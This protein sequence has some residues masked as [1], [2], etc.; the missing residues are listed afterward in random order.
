MSV[1]LNFTRVFNSRGNAR[2]VMLNQKLLKTAIA[3]ATILGAALLGDFVF[4]YYLFVT[5]QAFTPLNTALIAVL[6]GTPVSYYLISQRLDMQRVKEELC[7]SIAEKD[8]VALELGLRRQ[9]AE[10]AQAG[11][12]LALDQLRESEARYRMLTDRATDIIIRYN[13]Q[14]MIE[15]ASP[16][17]HQIGYEPA[18]LVGRNM[19]EFTHPDDLARAMK[20]RA[21]VT[22]GGTL[23]PDERHEFRTLC[24]GGEWRWLQGS[25]APIR[26]E[27]GAT[28]GAVTV[29]RDVTAR[30]AM[31][32]ELR[33]KRA[34]AEAAVRAKSEFLA[35]MTHELRTPL[36]A[37]IGFSGL[38]K[39]SSELSERSA[40]QIALIWEASQTL[41]GVVNDVLDF[42]KLEA[43]SIEPDLQAFDP[44][45]L[46]RSTV[47]LLSG[48]ALAKGLTVSVKVSG[49]EGPLMGDATR[50][51][52]V[53]LNF[54]SNAIKFTARG[55]IALTVSQRAD[56]EAR[57]LR[58]EVRDSGIGVPPEQAEAIF[59]RFTQGD[60]SI[61]R[62]FGGTGLGL[63][64]SKRIIEALGGEIGV[65]SAPG[66]GSTFWFEL[67][68]PP[69]QAA[70]AAEP[71]GEAPAPIAAALRLLVVDDNA[72]NRELITALLAPFGLDIETAVDG[73][74]AIEAVAR[75][76]FDLIL[77]DVQMPTMDGLT[78]TRR[79]RASAA[80]GAP[81]IPII[82][83][84]ANVL[85]EQV[86]RCLAAG[87]D[88][89]LG[90]PISPQKLLEAIGRWSPDARAP[91]IAG[92]DPRQ[93][94]A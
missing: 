37:I 48:Q 13:G 17:V 20:N 90:K 52:Q 25:P 84:T 73:V 92:P 6:V 14:G 40:R 68:A 38:L 69:A 62:Q 50:L 12:E 18:D 33:R 87:M 32:D 34:E 59:D 56:G 78:A 55:E 4:N 9:E 93:S 60:A 45:Q 80:P 85:T 66:E 29:L 53:M 7:A 35:N 1:F 76:P 86:E 47:E 2:I 36:N 49:D 89:H 21:I 8:H 74:E 41:L 46:A 15:F 57:R 31:E 42:S 10:R 65:I 88:D 51:R 26:D 94:A 75:E 64:I 16:S 24:A 61:S 54:L 67:T 91:L 22:S 72:V 5:P 81:R 39:D 11:A 43:G 44:E 82:A 71:A 23:D 27:T 58:V 19:A 3:V 63:A 77:M 28:I 70:L 79:I 83:M 30:R